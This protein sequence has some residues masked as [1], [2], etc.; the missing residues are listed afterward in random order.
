[1]TLSSSTQDFPIYTPS[2][3][4]LI[5]AIWLQVTITSTGNTATVAFNGDMPLGSL[6]TVTFSDANNKPIVGPFDSYTLAL[7]NKYGGYDALGDPRAS[8][9][10]SATTGSGSTGGS[11]AFV[12]R[13]PIEAVQRTGIGALQNQSSASQF[14]LKMTANTLANI[15]STAPSGTVT[16][17][18]QAFESGWWKGSN[19][20]YAQA[21]KAAGSTQYWVRGSYTALNGSVQQQLSQGLG[22]PIRN[23]INVNYATGGARSSADY[24]D[25]I[26]FLFR[27]A[28][29]WNV[30]QKLWQDQMSRTFNLN[31]TSLDTAGALDTGVFVLPFDTEFGIMPGQETGLGYLVTDPGDSFQ[32]I[33]SFAASST[34]YHVVNYLAPVGSPQVLQAKAA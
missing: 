27:G 17:K 8:A 14:Q 26:Q 24:P 2:P 4:N 23:I 20:A 16:L 15:Y 7:I 1:V 13:V 3:N 31:V 29:L 11:A 30:S 28:N 12:L 33:G 25:P 34:L 32:L 5:R 10:Y 9:V 19:T 21:P 22:Y 18:V 6:S